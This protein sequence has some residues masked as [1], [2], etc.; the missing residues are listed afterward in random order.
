MV[1]Y[2]LLFI[3]FLVIA[4]L[5]ILSIKLYSKFFSPK[6]RQLKNRIKSLRVDKKNK[7]MTGLIVQ[8]IDNPVMEFIK[9]LNLPFIMHLELMI[10][11]SGTT[12]KLQD[13]LLYCLLL[14]LVSFI[15]VLSITLTII[16][17]LVFLVMMTAAPIYY[18]YQLEQ[19]KIIKFNAQFPDALDHIARSLKAGNALVASIGLVAEDMPEPIASEFRQTFEEIN[20]GLSFDQS[21]NNLATRVKSN[22]LNFFVIALLI[23][24]ESGG[25]LTELLANLSLTMRDRV[26]LHGKIKTLAAEGKFSG[27]LLSIFPFLL[28]LAFYFINPEYMMILFTTPQGRSLCVTGVILMAIGYV[29]LMRITKIKV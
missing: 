29:W 4:S 7:I 1:N 21:L 28:G 14:F 9:S 8:D 6:A 16:L 27:N 24:R 25:N 2:P 17:K 26:K 3:V 22:D 23:Q 18:L 20:F 11:R 13:I 15:T 12:K 19:K 5:S 10:I